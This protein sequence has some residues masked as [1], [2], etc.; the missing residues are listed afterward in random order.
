MCVCVCVCAEREGERENAAVMT[1]TMGEQ[2][3]KCADN[4][5]W[6]ALRAPDMK[7]TLSARP[8]LLRN[9]FRVQ[10]L[11]DTTLHHYDITVNAHAKNFWF[12]FVC[13]GTVASIALEVHEHQRSLTHF[14]VYVVC[15]VK[16]VINCHESIL[17]GLA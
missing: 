11:G 13:K 5:D 6:I 3:E 9:A 17:S 12:K 7:T 10:T 15:S 4:V 1:Q 2:F 16:C 8:Q 14:V